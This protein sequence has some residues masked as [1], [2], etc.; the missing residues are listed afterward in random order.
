MKKN[1]LITLIFTC[2]FT[3][4]YPQAGEPDST[5]G[6][7]GIVR[8]DLGAPY[9]YGS[10]ALKVLPDSDGSMYVITVF[11]ERYVIS[12]RLSDGSIDFS[13]GKNGFSSLI[14]L[15]PSAMAMQADGKVVV[16]GFNVHPDYQ[17]NDFAVIRLNTDGSIDQTF[18]GDGMQTTDFDSLNN[19]V[20]SIAVQ[21]DGKIIVAGHTPT[22]KTWEE[23]GQKLSVVRYNTDGTLDTTFSG[24]GKQST[25]FSVKK[26]YFSASRS[27]AIQEDGKIVVAGTVS[28][29]QIDFALVRYNNDGSVDSTFATGGVQ[30][31]DF[32]RREDNAW[33]VAIQSDGKIVVGGNTGADFA[34]A[35]YNSD[36]SP[37]RSFSKDGKQKTDFG[38]GERIKSIA[39]QKDGKIVAAGIKSSNSHSRYFILAHYNSDGSLDSTF[40]KN[41]WKTTDIGS[42]Y[43]TESFR[44]GS[45]AFQADGKI[46]MAGGAGIDGG[47]HFFVYR[48]NSQGG[49]DNAFDDDG[50]I[51]DTAGLFSCTNY[52]STASQSDGKLV[53]A[54][55]TWNGSNFDLVVARY[56]S[57]GNLD[58]AFGSHGYSTADVG[59][60]S[61]IAKAV[62]IQQDGKIVAAVS[63]ALVRFNHNGSLDSSFDGDGIRNTDFSISSLVIDSNGKIVVGGSS[64]GRFNLMAAWIKHLVKMEYK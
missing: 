27:I 49:F 20:S 34:L 52:T 8:A 51:I 19:I 3:I 63:N 17:S 46:V 40:G 29:E 10:I 45:I 9:D 11:G 59:L 23:R 31:T 44:D 54:G 62:A 55:Q 32:G 28:H 21:D 41:G 2:C 48:F 36:G 61:D 37:D 57:I 4:A 50:K 47:G 5:F 15:V 18:G 7:N 39:I 58:D 56:S 53:V 25:L 42:A 16:A 43:G 12:K 30:I 1:T 22:G 64:I 33:S 60:G 24:D 13:Y 26:N 14:H 38:S 6:V 35:R